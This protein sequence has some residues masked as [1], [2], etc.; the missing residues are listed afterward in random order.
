MP[1][2]VELL[3]DGEDRTRANAA[4][5]LGNLVRNSSLL[6]RDIIVAGALQVRGAAGRGGAADVWVGLGVGGPVVESSRGR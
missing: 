4:G 2:L 1:P 3:R 5:A 6:C